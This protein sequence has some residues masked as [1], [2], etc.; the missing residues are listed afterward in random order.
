MTFNHATCGGYT[1]DASLLWNIN[2][3]PLKGVVCYFCQD[4]PHFNWQEVESF[5]EIK[6]KLRK[7]G[8]SIDNL[9]EIVI[10]ERDG[11]SRIKD[12]KILTDT[13]ELKISAKD[14]RNI[15]GPNLIKSTNF[16]LSIE[17]QDVVF[18]GKGWGHG[19]GMCQWGAYFMA[20]QGFSAPQ[21]LE[22]YYPQTNVKTL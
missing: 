13:G 1:E 19:V 17:K 15:I 16:N 6:E 18:E 9:K 10:L 20:K 7:S 22:Y 3:P 4:S 5:T 8:Y 2:I 11:S 21:I 14:F 12:L